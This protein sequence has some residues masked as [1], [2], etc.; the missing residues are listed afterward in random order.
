MS[1]NLDQLIDRIPVETNK[2]NVVDES[3][4]SSS[5][6]RYDGGARRMTRMTR[7]NTKPSSSP[8]DK[9]EEIP[10]S[11]FSSLQ[12]GDYIRYEKDGKLKIG[13]KIVNMQNNFITV[14]GYGN[15]FRLDLNKLE[16]V[17]RLKSALKTDTQT[18]KQIQP[19]QPTDPVVETFEKIG[20]KLLD[21]NLEIK[22]LKRQLS[23][24]ASDN[25][26][27]TSRLTTIET[28]LKNLFQYIKKQ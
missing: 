2:V 11:N 27:L 26:K 16:R 4:Y 21:E 25:E 14:A 10:R 28:N 19:M 24:L 12:V 1:Y 8:L 20:D 18:T 13:A 7:M 3:D 17:Y 15:V 6:N 9:Y 22:E 23:S 5:F